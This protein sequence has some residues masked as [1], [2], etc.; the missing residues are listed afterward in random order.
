M[1]SSDKDL[2]SQFCLPNSEHNKNTAHAN[3]QNLHGKL[4]LSSSIGVDIFFSLILSYFCRLVAAFN[5]CHGKLPLRKYM[6]TYPNDSI[7]SLRLCSAILQ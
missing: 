7:S 5:P 6:S 2:M 1:A 3:H 4:L